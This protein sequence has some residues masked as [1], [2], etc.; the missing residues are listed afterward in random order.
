MEKKWKA[1][2]LHIIEKNIIKMSFTSHFAQCLQAFKGFELHR[3]VKDESLTI[4]EY[5]ERG[6]E[7]RWF[8]HFIR[9][10]HLKFE[11]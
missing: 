1:N 2:L 9:L 4:L 11:I 10:D 6:L 5:C 8:L 7:S 3:V